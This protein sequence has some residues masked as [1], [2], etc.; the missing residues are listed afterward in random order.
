MKF[1]TRLILLIIIPFAL[2]A[3]SKINAAEIL[4]N[5]EL[6]R[7]PWIQMSM[8][9]TITDNADRKKPDPVYHL[10]FDNN[11]V[12]V[13]CMEPAV[14]KGNLLLMQNHEMWL[15]IKST[16]QPTKITPIQRLAGS[17]SFI[18]IAG[19]KWSAD[20]EVD[21]V[22][23]INEKKQEIYFLQLHAKS[24]DISYRKIYLWIDKKTNKPVK[25]DIYL[26]SDKLYKTIVF[27]KYE[28]VAGK[29]MNTQIEFTD[30]FN[31]ERK[32]TIN[33]SKEK[34]EKN[35]PANYFLKEKLAEDSKLMLSESPEEN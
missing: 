15:Y 21:S 19:L 11:K 34:S 6:K 2:H 10:F 12:L 18:D 23:I 30:H 24:N 8:Y 7:I 22:K 17:V 29:E 20:Y 33:F 35:L 27:T 3:Q 14:Q 13:A 31:K 28:T 5:A 16:T 25:E 9:A 4:R 1:F 26:S 32:T